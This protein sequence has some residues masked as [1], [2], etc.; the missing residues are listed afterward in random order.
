MPQCKARG[1]QGAG[2]AE[3]QHR[4]KEWQPGCRDPHSPALGTARVR[5][6]AGGQHQRLAGAHPELPTPLAQPSPVAVGVDGTLSAF[7]RVLEK[8]L[9]HR[10]TG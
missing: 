6:R 1:G 8:H 5:V 10:A 4:C 9:G 2:E 7:L 3:G